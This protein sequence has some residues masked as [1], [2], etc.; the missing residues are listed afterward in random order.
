MLCLL[1]CVEERAR[2]CEVLEER[3]KWVMGGAYFCI[4]FVLSLQSSEG[5][6][7]DLTGL[8]QHNSLGSEEVFV[9]LL[10]RFKGEHYAKQ[11][12]LKSC[13]TTGSGIRIKLWLARVMAVHQAC[14]R[15]TRP[16]FVNSKGYQSSTSEMNELFLE[17]LSEIQEDDSRLFRSDIGGEGDLPDKFN[18]F[19]LFRRGSD[20]RAV[21]MKAF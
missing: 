15:S 2:L 16:A 1:D 18:V 7:A 4:C 9:P 11:H 12:L 14:D 6:M 8:C 5:L 21:A 17:V 19:R 20:S 13:A 10:G 3:Y